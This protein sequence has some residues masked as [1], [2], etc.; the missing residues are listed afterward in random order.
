MP[1]KFPPEELQI[2]D[3]HKSLLQADRDMFHWLEADK[4]D[5]LGCLQDAEYL[6]YWGCWGNSL[7]EE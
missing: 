7:P 2:E 3:S 1:E 4:K 6:D 5:T